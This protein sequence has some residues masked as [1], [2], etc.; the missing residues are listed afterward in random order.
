MYELT[1]KI[2]AVWGCRL[3][4][5]RLVASGSM[6]DQWLNSRYDSHYAY[7]IKLYA[8]KYFD[9]Y[10]NPSLLSSLNVSNYKHDNILKALVAYS[11]FSGNYEEFRTKVKNAGVH[12]HKQNAL[13]AFLRIMDNDNH[14]GLGDWYK[15]AYD[16]L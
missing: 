9:C 5:S 14:K 12:Y 10:N 4:W 1:Q 15:K 6:F 2:R 8:K 7:M 16:I 13:L 3:A 11:K